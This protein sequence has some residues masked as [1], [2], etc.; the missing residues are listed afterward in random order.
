MTR[1]LALFL[2]GL[3]TA[4]LSAMATS[5]FGQN[6]SGGLP[7]DRVFQGQV[8]LPDF[9]G[10]DRKYASFRTRIREGMSTGPDFAGHYAIIQIGCGT[11]CSFV[12]VGDVATGQVYDFPYGGE[13]Y[14]QMQ[15]IRSA[16]NYNLTVVWIANERCHRDWLTWQRAS[17]TSIGRIDLGP[18]DVCERL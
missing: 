18:S 1:H 14:Q 5:A 12:L 17:F 15:I 16:K 10:R 9:A 8:R 13:E 7:T 11:G 2:A 3:F 6:P 4:V